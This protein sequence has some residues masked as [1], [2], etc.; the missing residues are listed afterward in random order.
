MSVSKSQ[1]LST[2]N[3]QYNRYLL[4]QTIEKIGIDTNMKDMP[5]MTLPLSKDVRPLNIVD[6][7]HINMYSELAR[8]IP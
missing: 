6:Q 7:V 2:Q 5:P 1:E 3:L 8:I 4:V